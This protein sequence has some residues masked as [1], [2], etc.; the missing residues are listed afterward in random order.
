MDLKANGHC[1]K[2]SVAGCPFES[3][4]KVK[5]KAPDPGHKKMNI[6]LRFHSWRRMNIGCF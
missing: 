6:L 2:V 1:F 4:K 5:K 3:Q